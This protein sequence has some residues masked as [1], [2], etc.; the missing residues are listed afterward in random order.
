MK[1]RNRKMYKTQGILSA[2]AMA[3]LATASGKASAVTV[4]AITTWDLS[5]YSSGTIINSPLASFGN[6]TA[7]SLGMTNDYDYSNGVTGSITTCDVTAQPGDVNAP[8][9]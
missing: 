4:Q 8:N 2:A 5:N 3:A 6:G 1:V 7:L 9:G